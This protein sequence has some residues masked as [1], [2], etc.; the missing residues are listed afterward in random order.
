M[1]EKSYSPPFTK[2]SCLQPWR[3]ALAYSRYNRRGRHNHRGRRGHNRLEELHPDGGSGP[4]PGSGGCDTGAAALPAMT[5]A[6]P[7]TPR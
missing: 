1:K 7:L 2:T 5:T 6:R 3:A 4:N